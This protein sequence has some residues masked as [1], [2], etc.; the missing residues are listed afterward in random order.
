M[1]NKP[2]AEEALKAAGMLWLGLS[3]AFVAQTLGITQ[4]KLKHWM[5]RDWWPQV[6]EQAER[7]HLNRMVGKARQVLDKT[8]EAGL[9][10][11]ASSRDRKQAF[12][13]ARFMLEHQDNAF[14]P[15]AQRTQVEHTHTIQHKMAALSDDDLRRL[16][17]NPAA[18]LPAAPDENAID[19][20][21]AEL[22]AESTAAANPDK[23]IQVTEGEDG[24]LYLEE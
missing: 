2:D 21:F 3:R 6:E 22:T 7:G 18:Q 15:Q 20:D 9:D 24:K 5:S 12:E 17:R 23:P 14:R 4:A 13:A 11:E 1:A 19:V 8:M 10:P 16:A